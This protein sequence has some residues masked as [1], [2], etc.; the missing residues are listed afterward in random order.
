MVYAHHNAWN[1]VSVQEIL[2]IISLFHCSM[3]PI[4][5]ETFQNLFIFGSEF[6]SLI[7]SHSWVE[8]QGNNLSILLR[9]I[10]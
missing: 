3:S 9:V 2:V 10:Q 5:V 8:S 6:F 4:V 1:I 7:I